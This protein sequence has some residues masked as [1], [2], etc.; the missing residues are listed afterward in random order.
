MKKN[1]FSRVNDFFYM[2]PAEDAAE[3]EFADPSPAPAAKKKHPQVQPAVE[4]NSLRQKKVI[5]M[6]E[7][8]R[9]K[10]KIM[11]VE[12]RAY[13][14]AKEIANRLKQNET[15]LVNFRSM[16]EKQARRV[17]DFLTGTVY[18]LAGDIRRVNQEIFLCTPPGIQIDGGEARTLME[19]QMFEN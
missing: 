16:D 12:P 4:K 13:G 1:L 18:S 10:R 15:I 19:E 17:I 11:I 14:D 5:T 3:E 6:S 9:H 7:E 8:A 2:D